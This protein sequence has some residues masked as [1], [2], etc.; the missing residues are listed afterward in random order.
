MALS[1]DLVRDS[2]LRT[3]LHDGIT[4]HVIEIA[5]QSARQRKIRQEQR[6]K[7][8]RGLGEGA[9]GI[10]WL[11]ELMDGESEVNKRAVKAIKKPMHESR[12]IDYSRELEAIAKFSHPRVS[13]PSSPNPQRQ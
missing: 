7:R 8:V 10:V 9:H 6:W 3:T 2:K 4:R 1:S 5:G 13:L 12:E 11:E